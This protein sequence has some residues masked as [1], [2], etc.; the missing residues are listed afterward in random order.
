[1]NDRLER[2]A[3]RFRR[4]ES[5][6]AGYSPLYRRLF[7]AV[8][9]WLEA[10]QAQS[11][12]LVDWL[13]QASQGRRSLDVTL[14]LAA[15][16]HRDVLAGEPAVAALG[17]Y[18]PTAG[19]T[20]AADDPQ[21][22]SALR[23]AILARRRPLGD[24]IRTANVQ[25]NE[26]GRGLCW[27]LPL[28]A[29]D[30]PAIHLV[31]LGASAGLNLV[32]ERRAFRLVDARTEA[33]VLDLGRARPVQFVTRFHGDLHILDFFRARLLP[34]ITSRTGC[35]V[36][37]F[38]LD[39]ERDRLTLKAFVWGDQVERMQRLQE[40]IEA[41]AP[42]QLSA[43]PVALYATGL[44][45]ELD[46]FW[47]DHVPLEPALPVAVYN[48]FMTPYLRDKGATLAERIGHWSAD[49]KRP[50]VWFQWEPAR[51]GRIPPGDE[52]CLWTAD[53]WQGGDHRRWELG[54]IHPHGSEGQLGRGL[55]DWYRFW[56]EQL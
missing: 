9:S 30:W 42:V 14:L 44:P 31:D 41:L 35:D 2:L 40:G 3:Y 29:I 48:T 13:L 54:W 51:D 50:V 17:R 38:T 10:P 47:A 20:K 32:A 22:A 16:L 6:A 37:P 4:Q 24:F 27:L 43:A 45:D 19:G 18:Y 56:R 33:L 5:F 7:A 34:A 25:T 49:Q 1:M 12:P 21:F 23:Q 53:L 15:G 11:D 28:L 52:W 26:T 39:S 8:S 46:I 36:R 55:A